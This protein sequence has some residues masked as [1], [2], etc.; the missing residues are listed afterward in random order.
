M[1]YTIKEATAILREVRASLPDDLSRVSD[2]KVSAALERIVDA[3]NNLRL[4]LTGSHF[5]TRETLIK[6]AE[7]LGDEYRR[8][9]GGPSNAVAERLHESGKS[10][11]G[12][13]YSPEHIDRLNTEARLG[14]VFISGAAVPKKRAKP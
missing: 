3:I 10:W 7:R 6:E 11:K 5:G 14:V 12:I 4:Y 9:R 13:P 1:S 8:R 2:K